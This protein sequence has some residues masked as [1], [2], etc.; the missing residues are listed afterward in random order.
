MPRNVK[1]YTTNVLGSTEL[2]NQPHLILRDRSG[3][4]TY[5][6]EALVRANE[7]KIELDNSLTLTDGL[8]NK[9]F[10]EPQLML[11]NE[12]SK[13]LY[14]NFH[15]LYENNNLIL[16]NKGYYQLSP[17][18]LYSGGLFHST[19]RYTLGSLFSEW[20]TNPKLKKENGFIYKISGSMLSGM[21]RY[22]TINIENGKYESETIKRLNGEH[23]T[24]YLNIFKRLSESPKNNLVNDLKYT[25]SLI[26][27]L[28]LI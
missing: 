11:V 25:N 5:M 23:W 18:W 10:T 17:S 3:F 1:T 21:N 15:T 2:N 22:E 12:N 28:N 20:E 8:Y 16:N 9:W 19:L 7:L 27:Q 4:E 26:T 6:P 24:D 14:R 13:I